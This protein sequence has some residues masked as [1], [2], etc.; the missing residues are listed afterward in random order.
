[1]SLPFEIILNQ[2][3]YFALVQAALIERSYGVLFGPGLISAYE[4]ERE[5]ALFPR[6]ILDRKIL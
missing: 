6:I 4:L 5:Q 3:R 1:M 2:L